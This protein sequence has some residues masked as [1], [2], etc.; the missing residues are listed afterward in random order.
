MK[1]ENREY[2]D[3]KERMSVKMHKQFKLFFCV[4]LTQAFALLFS[5]QRETK[6]FRVTLV[7]RVHQDRREP[8]AQLVF[9]VH[10]DPREL[11]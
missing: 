9:L 8:R 10:P 6:E 3:P 2:L 1:L 11:Q 7:P 4:K 5:N